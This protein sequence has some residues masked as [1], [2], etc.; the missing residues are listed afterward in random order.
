MPASDP[1]SKLLGKAG[2]ALGAKVKRFPSSR[3]RLD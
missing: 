2:T 1:S 3:I